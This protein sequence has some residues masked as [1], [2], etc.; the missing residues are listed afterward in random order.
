MPVFLQIQSIGGLMYFRIVPSWMTAGKCRMCTNRRQLFE[1]APFRTCRAAEGRLRLWEN[2]ASGSWPLAQS[3]NATM[4]DM[5]ESASTTT[6][7]V[8]PHTKRKILRNLKRASCP[9][10]A[11]KDAALAVAEVRMLQQAGQPH[12]PLQGETV[13]AAGGPLHQGCTS[14]LR[15]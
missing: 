14:L 13:S 2:F 4:R 12:Y 15:M 5:Q 8:W 11:C 6:V 3:S 10:C 1:A 9:H 7:R